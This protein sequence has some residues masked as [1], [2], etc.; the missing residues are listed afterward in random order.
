MNRRI[1]TSMKFIFENRKIILLFW[2]GILLLIWV[3]FF[4]Y[5]NQFRAFFDW[6]FTIY[7]V[8]AYSVYFLLVSLRGLTFIP[9]TSIVIPVIPFTT[10]W[11]LLII[12]LIG[13]AITSLMIYYLSEGLNL[14][15]YFEKKHPHTIKLLRRWFERYE[16]PVIILRALMPLTPTDLICYVAGTLEVDVK[17]MIL[18]ILIGEGI[19]CTVYIWW[20]HFL[21]N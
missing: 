2:V 13:T 20:A 10:W 18:W 4:F 7:P 17:K 9:L 1:S 11:L 19:I 6:L 8:L 5:K 21:L 14:D 16:L 3:G 12:T 15:E